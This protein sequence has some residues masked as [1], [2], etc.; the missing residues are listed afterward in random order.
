MDTGRTP[1]LPVQTIQRL[2]KLNTA[3]G[4]LGN[5]YT[6][7]AFPNQTFSDD[8]QFEGQPPDIQIEL[9]GLSEQK[10]VTWW[11]TFK[12]SHQWST[13]SQNCSTTVAD[14]LHAGNAQVD[15]GDTL[16]AYNYP[17]TPAKVE[18]YANAIKKHGD[19]L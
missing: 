7:P 9:P 5:I 10:I 1:I 11:N 6:A 12:T 3:F 17:W 16:K 14:A 13:F 4:A 18:N 2:E 19:G 8:V 15:L